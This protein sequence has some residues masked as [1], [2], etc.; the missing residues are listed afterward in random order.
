LGFFRPRTALRHD[1]EGQILPDDVAVPMNKRSPASLKCPWRCGWMPNRS[2][3]RC[4]VDLEMPVCTDMVRTLQ[5]VA[6]AAGFA[7]RCGSGVRLW[8]R[9]GRSG[10]AAPSRE[11]VGESVRCP[12]VGDFPHQYPFLSP[13]FLVLSVF[14]CGNCASRRFTWQVKVEE[15]KAPATQGRIPNDRSKRDR[16]GRSIDPGANRPAIRALRTPGC[17]G[18]GESQ[19]P[20]C[21]RTG[22]PWSIIASLACSHGAFSRLDALTAHR[23]GSQRPSRSWTCS[24]RAPCRGAARAHEA[25]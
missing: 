8:H 15:G 4:T 7:G 11:A 2:N 23:H 5:C 16:P 24:R 21:I 22:I 17:G 6:L 18:L 9:R 10:C 1:R 19:E 20:R 13:E 3:Q 14:A 12:L 25:G